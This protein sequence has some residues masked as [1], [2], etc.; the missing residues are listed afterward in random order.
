MDDIAGVGVGRLCRLVD[1]EAAL[2]DADS[3]GIAF[4]VSRF[5][6]GGILDVC[7]WC[8]E[9][10]WSGEGVVVL[11]GTRFAGGDGVW[12]PGNGVGIV[13]T[14]SEVCA[15]GDSGHGAVALVVVVDNG[16]ICDVDATVVLIG[17]GAMDDIAG[18]G[19]GRLCHL[20]DVE[21][22][23]KGGNR[24][25]IGGGD[26]VGQALDVVVGFDGVHQWVW[27]TLLDD[28]GV[29]LVIGSAYEEVAK[30]V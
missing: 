16:D 27:V 2:A 20:G 29:A 8:G 4:V 19:G 11:N 5:D 24:G 13:G 26:I 10:V 25:A 1:G 18:A 9:G 30:G 7:G 21:V 14:G 22:W 3:L 12:A 28:I 23:A 17:D 6:A 15:A